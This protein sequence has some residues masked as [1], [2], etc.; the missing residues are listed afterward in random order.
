MQDDRI[1]A[2][3]F[4]D[5]E[6]P[7]SQSSPKTFKCFEEYFQQNLSALNKLN[8]AAAGTT[9][10]KQVWRACKEIPPGETRTYG[11][12]AKAI[13]RPRAARAVGQALNANP[14]LLVIPCHRV[15]SSS[16]GCGGFAAGEARKRWLL[17]HEQC[18]NR[19]V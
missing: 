6:Q 11:E 17:E 1:T 19:D 16:K 14:L 12:I 15:V 5:K 18:L 3:R 2:I 13:G 9:F 7:S 4:A 10:Q 8:C